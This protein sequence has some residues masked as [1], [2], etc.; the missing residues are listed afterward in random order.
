MFSPLKISGYKMFPHIALNIKC[1]MDRFRIMVIC[2]GWFAVSF[3]GHSV[4]QEV[5]TDQIVYS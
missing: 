4:F 3:T 2:S 5:T 1:V